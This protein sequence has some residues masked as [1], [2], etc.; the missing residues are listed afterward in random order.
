MSVYKWVGPEDRSKY[1]PGVPARDLSED[2]YN[3][4][5]KEQQKAVNDSGLYQ[6]PKRPKGEGES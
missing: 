5:S 2:E 4:L 1:V 6:A 3:A